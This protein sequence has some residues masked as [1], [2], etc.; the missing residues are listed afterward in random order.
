MVCALDELN[1]EDLSLQLLTFTT[2]NIKDVC[3]GPGTDSYPSYS[4]YFLH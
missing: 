2:P 4:P 1:A 3:V